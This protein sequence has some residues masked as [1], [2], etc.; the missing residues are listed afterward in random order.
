M[1]IIQRLKYFNNHNDIGTG[2]GGGG[3]SSDYWLHQLPITRIEQIRHIS[4]L[5]FKYGSENFPSSEEKQS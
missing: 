2:K 5:S 1:V 4:F 3:E